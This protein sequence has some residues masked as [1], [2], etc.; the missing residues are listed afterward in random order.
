MRLSLVSVDI[1]EVTCWKELHL[2]RACEVP[3]T[4]VRVI[5]QEATGCR[6]APKES[7]SLWIGNSPWLWLRS[8][9]ATNTAMRKNKAKG[10]KGK[11]SCGL[12]H[13]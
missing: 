6:H 10:S 8:G 4:L 2:R 5:R 7:W 12:H 11:P 9:E 13:G 3:V 1:I